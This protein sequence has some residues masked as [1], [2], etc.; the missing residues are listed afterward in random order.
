M[1]YL[2]TKFKKVSNINKHVMDLAKILN[3]EGKYYNEKSHSI[4]LYMQIFDNATNNNAE[5]NCN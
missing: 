5:I 4:W 3:K 2:N 1:W